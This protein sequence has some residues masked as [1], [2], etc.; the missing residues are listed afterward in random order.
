MNIQNK[1]DEIRRKPE[2]IRIRYAWACS[3]AVTFLVVII[4]IVSLVAENKK[5][6]AAELIP[7]KDEI[8]NQFNGLNDQKK[9]IEDAAKQIKNSA[10][11]QNQPNFSGGY[12]PSNQN[13][14]IYPNSDTETNTDEMND[15]YQS[16]M[17]GENNSVDQNNIP[18]QADNLEGFSTGN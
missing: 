14:G 5:E 3:I 2:H 17:T 11:Q 1:I 6:N 8:V 13:Q 15:L 12:P 18:E 7:N 16:G 9:S 4:W 10:E